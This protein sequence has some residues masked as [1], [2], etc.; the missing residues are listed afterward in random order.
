MGYNPKEYPNLQVGYDKWPIDPNFQRDI[1]FFNQPQTMQQITQE[2]WYLG[3][4]WFPQWPL[5]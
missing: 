3:V 5:K 2:V 4:L 1:P